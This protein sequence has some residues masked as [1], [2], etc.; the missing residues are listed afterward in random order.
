MEREQLNVTMRGGGHKLDGEDYIVTNLKWF[1]VDVKDP[2]MMKQVQKQSV[3]LHAV[4]TY[5]SGFDVV[6]NDAETLVGDT[7]VMLINGTAT[8][9]IKI[10]PIAKVTTEM[11][12]KKKFRIAIRPSVPGYNH[13]QV[14]TPVFK[15]MVKID[16]KMPKYTA[17]KTLLQVAEDPVRLPNKRKF[18][19][20]GAETTPLDSLCA[21]AVENK[22]LLKTVTAQ[23]GEILNE[24]RALR[25]HF[26]EESV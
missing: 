17:A 1:W 8:F 5:E 9:R 15:I 22:E 26:V 7:E 16:R 10:N 19:G 6:A 25:A 24:L 14:L 20:E 13:L 23:Q 3:P 12:D 18:E 2:T 11:H 21:L 4:L